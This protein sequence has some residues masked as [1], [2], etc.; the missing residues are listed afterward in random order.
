MFKKLKKIHDNIDVRSLNIIILLISI[1]FYII[2]SYFANNII[3]ILLLY[4]LDYELFYHLKDYRYLRFIN[5]I[6]PIMIIA[7]FLLGY[8]DLSFIHF[9]LLHILLWV[10]KVLLVIF[11]IVNVFLIIKDRNIKYVKGRRKFKRRTFNELRKRE[12]GRFKKDN[13]D[14]QEKYI[15]DN[16]I[17]KDSDYYKVIND[18]LKNKTVNDLEEYVYLNYLR[19]Y[20]NKKYNKRNIFDKLNIVFLLIHVIILLLSIWR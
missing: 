14:Y 19:F 13:I 20:K 16:E 17:N 4:I 10:I 3:I 18:N 15:L 9:D 7:Y 6:L 2:S 8:L 12:I 11:Y 5:L 1:V